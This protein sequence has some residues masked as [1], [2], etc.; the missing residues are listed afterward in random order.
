MPARGRADAVAIGVDVQEIGP[1]VRGRA[2]GALDRAFELVRLFHHL[3]LD[4]KRL[5]GLGVVDVGAAEIAGHVAAGLELPAAVMPDAVAL[6]VVAVIV[7][8]D[9]DD[10]RLV[11]RLG[12]QRLRAGEAEA[13][14]A[15]DGNH[16]HIRPRELGAERRRQAP[17]QH[18]RTG[19]DVVLVSAAE[20]QERVDGLAGIDVAD[21]A[22]VL[23]EGAFELEPDALEAHGGALRIFARDALAELPH[24]RA[25]GAGAAGALLGDLLEPRGRREVADRRREVG[26]REPHI[27]DH[28]EIDR[29]AAGKARGI[30]TERDQSVPC[31]RGTSWLRRRRSSAGSWPRAACARPWRYRP[32]RDGCAWARRIW[33]GPRWRR[34]PLRAACW[35]AARGRPDRRATSTRTS[36]RGGRFP[37]SMTSSSPPS[38]I[39]LWAGS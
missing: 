23:L 26:G 35:S 25:V 2:L 12:P 39:L 19:A 8:H 34:L 21:V 22:G 36:C 37:E 16:G 29:A 24:L 18:V 27:G 20:G 32:C 15:D 30:E 17:S 28:A 1:S 11:A 9:V 13:A 10:R 6:V 4:A 7:E 3:A 31:W 5:G 14:V 38:T 33:P